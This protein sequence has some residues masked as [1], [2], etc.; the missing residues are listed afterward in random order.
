[1]GARPRMSYSWSAGAKKANRRARSVLPPCGRCTALSSPR[2]TVQPQA[3]G[4]GP[5]ARY[6][7]CR[8]L[9]AEKADRRVK[10][11]PP[12]TIAHLFASTKDNSPVADTGAQAHESSSSGAGPWVQ[13]SQTAARANTAPPRGHRRRQKG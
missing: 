3:W 9:C 7:A 10:S 4:P 5:H 6:L 11:T 2:S 12:P 13:R 8:L 1:M